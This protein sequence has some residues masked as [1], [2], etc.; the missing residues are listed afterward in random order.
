MPVTFL[1]TT[2]K[3]GFMKEIIDKLGLVKIKN[4]CFMICSV[5]RMRKAPEWR[6]YLEKVHLIK[7]LPIVYKEFLKV[8]KKI[9]QF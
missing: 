7:D 9:T 1:K 4:F 6:K 5:N 3:A 2:P 8:N